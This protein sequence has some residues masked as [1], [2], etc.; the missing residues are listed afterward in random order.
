VL[1][2]VD[3]AGRER[4]KNNNKQ[5]NYRCARFSLPRHYSAGHVTTEGAADWSIVVIE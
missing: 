5:P 2:I 4:K 3:I 1:D